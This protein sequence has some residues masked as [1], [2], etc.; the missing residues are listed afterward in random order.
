MS[1]SGTIIIVDDNKGVLTAVEI[2]LKSYFSKVV[3]LSSPVTL[4]TVMQE[5]MPEVILLDMNFTSGI[6]TGNEGLFWLHE[7]KKVRPELPIVLFTA[8]A[9]IELAIRGIKEGATDFIV[10]PWNN[11]KLVETLQTAAQSVIVSVAWIAFS[12]FGMLPYYIGGYI[13]SVTDAFFETM[14]GFSSTGATIMNNIESMPHGILFW[15]AMTQWIG[16]LGIVFFTIAV[17]PIFGMGGIQVFA[18]EASGPTHDKVH[19]RIGVT[20]KWIWGIYA[21]MTGTLII[22]LVFGGMGLFDSICHAFTTTSTGGFSTKQTSIEYYHSPYIDYVISVFMFLSGVN[23][24]LLLL[25]FNGKIKKFIHDA[26]LKFY[27]MSVAFFTVFIAVWLYQTSSMGAEEAFR[28]SLFQV[29]SLQTSTGFA[30]ADYMLW[31]SILWGCLLIVMIMGACAGSTTGGIK[32]IRMVILFKVAKNEFKHILHPNAVLPVRVNKQVIS[33]SIQSTVLA[34]TFLYAIIAII[35]I[36]VMMG[37]G[38]GF[39]ESI[40]TVISSIGNMGPGLGTCGPAFSWSELPD[41]AKW[42][43]SFLMLLGRLELF[44]VLLLFSSDFW[45]RN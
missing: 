44:T 8:Y 37:F 27:F 9:D 17:L 28:K 31:P 5:E 19:P 13:P 7:I 23:F 20:A 40:G 36:L 26:E 18:A 33:P 4:I 29:I 22:L 39:L 21:G 38:V 3:T 11:Q 30:T 25:M 42:L 34:F 6:N 1:K 15:R 2:L 14:S 41:T 32:C 12:F 10:K 35:S 24:T 43:L 45:K 16:G